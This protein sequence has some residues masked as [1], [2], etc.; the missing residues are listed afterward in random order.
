MTKD[1]ALALLKE[2]A[3]LQKASGKRRFGIAGEQILGVSLPDIRKIAKRIGCDH[4]LT[5]ALWDSGIHEAQMLATLVED[6]QAVT[7]E[8]LESWILDVHSW[9][10]CDGLCNNLIRHTPFAE[11]KLY[12]W[13]ARPEE[14]VKR[15]GFVLMAVLAIHKKDWPDRHFHAYFPLIRSGAED[16]RNFVKKAVNWA[17]R[18]IGK[19]SLALRQAARKEAQA[20]LALDCASAMWVARDALRE[21]DQIAR[22]ES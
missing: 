10:I 6:P 15:A 9:D 18:Q 2:K 5:L 19:R 17:L 3:N 16:D 12:D 4:D 22:K 11:D 7:S 20:L 8:Q 14:F 1:E 13:V 21:F